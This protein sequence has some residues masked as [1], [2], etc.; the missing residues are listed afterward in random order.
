MS[1]CF[2]P[3]PFQEQQ[4]GTEREQEVPVLAHG[5][6][7]IMRDHIESNPAMKCTEME[8]DPNPFAKREYE[9][10]PVPEMLYSVKVIL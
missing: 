4:V 1:F 8:S 7:Q 10:V 2:V 6:A 3:G 5:V 9:A